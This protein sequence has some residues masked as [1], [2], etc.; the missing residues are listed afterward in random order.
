MIFIVESGSTKSDWVLLDDKNNQSFYS[1]M[2]FNP[3]FHSADLIESELKNQI[4]ALQNCDQAVYVPNSKSDLYNYGFRPGTNMTQP[5]PDLF[6]TPQ[7]DQ[8]NPLPDNLHQAVFF[9]PTRTQT[10]DAHD[11]PI[12]KK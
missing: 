10:M 7:F 5:F 2:G 11:S 3:Y 4:Y 9:N 6:N 8:C 12:P 1:T